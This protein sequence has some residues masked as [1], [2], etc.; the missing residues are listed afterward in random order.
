[1]AGN[2]MGRKIIYAGNA[3]DSLPESLILVLSG[4]AQFGEH[5]QTVIPQ[6]AAVPAG[7]GRPQS[8]EYKKTGS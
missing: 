8:P 5:Q 1:M 3:V 6:S 7:E 2:R 4:F